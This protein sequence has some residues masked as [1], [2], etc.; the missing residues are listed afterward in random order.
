MGSNA[1]LFE[2]ADRASLMRELGV[3]E[4][5]GRPNTP[6]TSHTPHTGQAESQ[7]VAEVA[8]SGAEHKT[9]HMALSRFSLFPYAS[10]AWSHTGRHM[11]KM[12]SSISTAEH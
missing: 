4:R 6:H 8:L 7:L 1:E 3:E 12:A 9:V 5:A 11:D 10:A 2:A